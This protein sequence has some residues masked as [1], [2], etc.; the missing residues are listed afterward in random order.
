MYLLYEDNS[1]LLAVPKFLLLS[2]IVEE[3]SFSGQRIQTKVLR[4]YPVYY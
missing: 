4:G 1:M 2:V 3:L